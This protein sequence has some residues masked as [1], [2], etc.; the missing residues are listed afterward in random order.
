[1]HLFF[2]PCVSGAQGKQ[3]EYDEQP[4]GTQIEAQIV[5]KFVV[6][7]DLV[8]ERRKKFDVKDRGECGDTKKQC[9]E[10]AYCFCKIEC[11]L[12][13]KLINKIPAKKDEW[14]KVPKTVR[15]DGECCEKYGECEIL[16]FGA[17]VA[18]CVEELVKEKDREP[19]KEF[20]K[21]VPACLPRPGDLPI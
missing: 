2:V 6:K 16:G 9:R 7:I 3:R 20:K 15:E 5:G 11:F 1:M 17:S 19:K 14:Q 4:V 21:C 8:Y 13:K 10:I 18:R 12:D